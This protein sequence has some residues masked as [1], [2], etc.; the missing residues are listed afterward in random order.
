MWLTKSSQCFSAKI[1]NQ[2]FH[3]EALFLHGIHAK[4]P[5]TEN[6]EFRDTAGTDV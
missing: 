1:F 2:S 4:Q 3:K 5:G 6:T